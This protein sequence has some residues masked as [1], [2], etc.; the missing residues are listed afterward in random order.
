L[1]LSKLEDQA[2]VSA[3]IELRRIRLERWRIVYV[4][5]EDWQAVV[6]L[7]IHQRPPYDYE[8]LSELVEGLKD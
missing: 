4:V 8:D 5:D 3:G 2:D 1:D 6:V 7:A